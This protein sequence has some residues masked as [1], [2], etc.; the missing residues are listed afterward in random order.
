ME[1]LKA[2]KDARRALLEYFD[3]EDSY[4]LL[5]IEDHT[6][7][8]WTIHHDMVYSTV[9]EMTV[10]TVKNGA[11][12]YDT[13]I[14]GSV[15]IGASERHK[16]K[17]TMILLSLNSDTDLVWAIFDNAHEVENP[18]DELIEELEWAR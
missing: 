7:Y 8:Y 18:S 1:L 11:E 6:G 14:G 5:P 2:Y 17:Y 12:L 16:D 10:E 3:F 15:H 4:Q 9:G 13:E